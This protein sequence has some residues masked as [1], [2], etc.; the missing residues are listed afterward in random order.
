M[1]HT[2]P[3]QLLGFVLFASE[4]ML[5]SAESERTPYAPW[6]VFGSSMCVTSSA[7]CSFVASPHHIGRNPVKVWMRIGIELHDISMPR[8]ISGISSARLSLH[9]TSAV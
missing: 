2:G 6:N 9:C 7:A 4:Y 1:I 5:S 3:S 8:L